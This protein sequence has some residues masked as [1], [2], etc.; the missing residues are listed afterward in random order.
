MKAESFVIVFCL[1]G[2]GAWFTYAKHA[3][4]LHMEGRPANEQ[5]IVISSDDLYEEIRYAGRIN[6]NADESAIETMSPNGYLKYTKNDQLLAVVADSS[7]RIVYTL[8]RNGQRSNNSTELPKII[9]EAIKETIAWGIDAKPRMEKVYRKGG[10]QALLYAMD[11]LKNGSLQLQYAERIYSADS[12]STT[13]LARLLLKLSGIDG[14]DYEKEQLLKK[15]S[16]EQLA[17]SSI[18]TA[19]LQSVKSISAD[20]AKTNLLKKLIDLPSLQQRFAAIVTVISS[21]PNEDERGRA[22]NAVIDK[23]DSGSSSASLLLQG[24]NELHNDGQKKALI[25]NWLTKGHFPDAQWPQLLDIISGDGLE[26]DKAALYKKLAT[27]SLATEEQWI[28]LLQHIARLNQDELK[29]GLLIDLWHTIPK[30]NQ[31]KAS[32]VKTAATI[33]ADAEYGRAIRI[34]E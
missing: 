22:L 30:T 19:Y 32:F 8:F 26:N 18:F 31:V 2:A 6:F 16:T 29:A 1:V 28:L 11:S 10:S 13:V 5:N 12:V 23:V 33:T 3:G 7:G 20:D 9:T 21:T 27:T 17:D 15:F 25:S 4:N 14:N 24:I 34:T